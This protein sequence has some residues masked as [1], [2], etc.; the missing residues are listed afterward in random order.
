MVTKLEVYHTEVGDAVFKATW[1][2]KLKEIERTHNW[3]RHSEVKCLPFYGLHA[4]LP[5]GWATPSKDLQKKLNLTISESPTNS[6]ITT[7]TKSTSNSSANFPC[8][9]SY[10]LPC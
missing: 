8:Q 3:S 9:L 4:R 2:R 5:Y 1:P 10:Q 6:P 7:T